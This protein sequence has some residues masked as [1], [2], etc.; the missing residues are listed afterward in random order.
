MVGLGQFGMALAEALSSK[1]FEIIAVDRRPERVR[2]AST[3]AAEALCFDPTDEEALAAAAPAQRDL[4]VCAIGDESRESSI[5]CTALLRQMGVRRVVA[6]AND[7]LHER[8]L[9]LVGAHEVV[10]PERE[11]GQRFASR[12]AYQDLAGEMPLGQDLVISEVHVP[13]VMQGRSLVDLRLPSRFGV[14]VVAIRRGAGGDVVV[15]V[16]TEPLASGD[17]LLL[18]GRR[19]AVPRMLERL[20]R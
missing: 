19:G 10:N 13:P 3:F 7:P 6:R 14:T 2:L 18:V 16:A 8:I 11:F 12:L 15:P 4:C 5:I 17:I 1:D 20:G 9:R